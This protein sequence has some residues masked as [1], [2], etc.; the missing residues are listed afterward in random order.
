MKYPTTKKINN[1]RLRELLIAQDYVWKKYGGGFDVQLGDDSCGI[2]DAFVFFKQDRLVACIELVGYT[3]G[4]INEIISHRE[5]KPFRYELDVEKCTEIHQRQPH[6]FTLIHKK[7]LGARQYSRFDAQE[8]ILLVHTEVYV[9][10][11]T[12]CFAQDG[13]MKMNPSVNNFMHHKFKIIDELK[14]AST[15]V[16]TQWDKIDLIDYTHSPIIDQCPIIEITNQNQRVD[17]SENNA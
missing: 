10:N 5:I 7:I 8:L 4:K 6:P 17:L 15:S 3:L 9:K 13:I 11:N 14:I 12:L 1:A 2:P 16:L